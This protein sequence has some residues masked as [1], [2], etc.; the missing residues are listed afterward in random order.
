MVTGPGP[1]Y[2]PLADLYHARVVS[3]FDGHLWLSIEVARHSVGLLL[4]SSTLLFMSGT[5]TSGGYPTCRS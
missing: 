2:A 3:D 5:E 1:Y 4:P